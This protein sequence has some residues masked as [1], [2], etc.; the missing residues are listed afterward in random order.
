MHVLF[1]QE[2]DLGVLSSDIFVLGHLLI[3]ATQSRGGSPPLHL[4]SEDS[5]IDKIL[6]IRAVTNKY[7]TTSSSYYYY[8]IWLRLGRND[9]S[10]IQTLAI[11]PWD[12]KPT[13]WSFLCILDVQNYPHYNVKRNVG[14]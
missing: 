8:G 10:E 7:L 1:Q 2:E 11:L 4:I 13:H 9:P 14:G 3:G 5:L 6:R 12:K